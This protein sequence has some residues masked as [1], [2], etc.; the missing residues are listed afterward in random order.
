MTLVSV[1]GL[2]SW[3]FFDRGLIDAAAGLQDLTGEPVLVPLSQ[4]H[5]YHHRVFLTPPW[6]E[7]YREDLERR[8][9]FGSAIFEYS[10]LLEVYPSLG[11]DVSVLPKTGV[12]ERAEFILNALKQE[13]EVEI[14]R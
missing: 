2:E 14:C 11:Y 8:H 10:R 13:D 6:P 12:V 9:D 3:V 4:A 1:K 5:R 7:L